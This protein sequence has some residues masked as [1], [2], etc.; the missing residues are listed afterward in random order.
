MQ[1]SV[2]FIFPPKGYSIS[3]ILKY[4]TA[5]FAQRQTINIVLA[6]LTLSTRF[7]TKLI[8]S[9]QNCYLVYNSCCPQSL[10]NSKQKQLRIN[11]LVSSCRFEC[12]RYI[13]LQYWYSSHKTIIQFC[14]RTTYNPEQN[15]LRTIALE[16]PVPKKTADTYV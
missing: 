11:S 14:N 1:W 12:F 15:N 9:A 3:D 2:F 5:R 8:F 10:A 6:V 7:T 16:S 4:S 13:L